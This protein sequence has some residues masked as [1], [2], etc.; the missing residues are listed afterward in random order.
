MSMLV[1]LDQLAP[2]FIKWADKSH[3]INTENKHTIDSIS[4]TV[5]KQTTDALQANM[6]NPFTLNY[7]HNWQIGDTAH[8]KK[9]M[10]FIKEFELNDFSKKELFSDYVEVYFMKTE[11]FFLNDTLIAK[12]QKQRADLINPRIQLLSVIPLKSTDRNENWVIVL[13]DLLNIVPG[14]EQKKTDFVQLFQVNNRGK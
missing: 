6:P 5:R 2:G 12:L 7:S 10:E 3:H 1:A 8:I 14:K 9:V 11:G 4:I 13:G